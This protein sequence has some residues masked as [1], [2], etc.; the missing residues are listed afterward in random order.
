M[1]KKT[2]SLRLAVGAKELRNRTWT[3]LLGV[4]YV[5]YAL[6]DPLPLLPGAAGAGIPACWFR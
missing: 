4:S 5:A 2:A 6:E 3:D 1:A